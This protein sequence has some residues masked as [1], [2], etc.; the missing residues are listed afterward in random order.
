MIRVGGILVAAAILLCGTVAA[1]AQNR[2]APTPDTSALLT[3]DTMSHDQNL[4][5]VTA[6]GHVEIAQ[7]NR[8][9]M[10]DTV[11]YSEKD[12]KV[13]A[14]GNVSLLESTGDVLFA[15]YMELTDEMK[16]G[17]IS[18]VKVLLS[19]NS[20]LAANTAER[21]DGNRTVLRKGVYSPCNLCAEDPTKAPVWQVRAGQV[22]HDK[23]K[24]EIEYED[25]V[26]EVFGVPI[27]YAPY[28]SHPDP[29]V[30]RKSGFLVP[31]AAVNNFFGVRTQLPYY[32]VTSE[33]SDVTITPQYSTKQGLQL[34]ADYR[35]RF[36]AGEARFDGSITRAEDA[37]QPGSDETRYH[38]R[39]VSRFRVAEQT[40]AGFDIFRASDDT[41]TRR[42]NIPDGQYNTLTSRMFGET[43]D[44][45][46][47]LGVNAY[48]FQGLRRDDVAGRT[49]F[50][51]PLVNYNYTG[52]PDEYGGR[53][54]FDGNVLSLYRTAGADVRRGST[55]L[56]WKLPYYAPM[57]DVY[58]FTAA[59]R[60]DGYWLDDFVP[61]GSPPGAVPQTFAGRV[62]PLAALD[63]RMPF[64]RTEGS[65]QQVI[66]P[67]ANVTVSPFGG[68]P[69]RI[70]N[71]DSQSFEFDETN[72]FAT[73][74]FP[75]LDRVDDGPRAS[76]GVR[77]G[78]YGA[79][80]GYSE[81]I[82]GQSV[83]YKADD[84][85]A[86]D[87]GL[88]G[89]SSDYVAR[90]TFAPSSFFSLTDRLRLARESYEVKRHEVT[91]TVG[92]KSLRLSLTYAMLDRNS[93]TSELQDREAGAAQLTAQLT[94][95]YSLTA[96]HLR[97][98]SDDGG[99]LRTLVGLRYL[100]ECTEILWFFDRTNT[101]DRDI[102]PSTTVGVRL[103]LLSLN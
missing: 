6:R 45:R 78:A 52:D 11:S 74:R 84:T 34:G 66:E 77:M 89:H 31:S 22:V 50:V 69:S 27:A 48:S 83:R 14:S 43:V 87:T 64:V 28:F 58:T 95:Y 33:S 98:L 56:N 51:L 18:G 90:A 12:G 76:Y 60:G 102:K 62:R 16:N 10:A 9:L 71:E 85:F 53:F 26:F 59:I 36:E 88:D 57:G 29:T 92:P 49:P 17:F 67:I 97:D 99:T 61:P 103:R 24:Q 40:Q 91:A 37:L 80:G 41:Y 44:G 65:V 19:D 32:W 4:G 23:E 20:R 54:G 3:A 82:V 25:A 38:I 100:D 5:I 1:Q 47:F 75:G 39:G 13:T 2:L 73:N 96:Q 42:Y 55:N 86:P 81:L 63:W 93:F 35:Q 21:T 79:G 46:Q 68:N 7:G 72:L 70:P 30:K 94:K 101:L 8:V 15:N